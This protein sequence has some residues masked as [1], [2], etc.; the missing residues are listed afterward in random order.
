MGSCTLGIFGPVFRLG[1]SS[2]HLWYEVLAR[3]CQQE[4]PQVRHRAHFHLSL[5]ILRA[6]PNVWQQ[7][8]LREREQ[9]G[10]HLRFIQEHVQTDR[11]QLLVDIP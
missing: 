2:S 8:V 1:S 7:H 4:I 9:P 6:R 5:R 3:P 10:V 11:R